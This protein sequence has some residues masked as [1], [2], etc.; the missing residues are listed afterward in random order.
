M[1][2]LKNLFIFLCLSLTISVK[3]Q[4]FDYLQSLRAYWNYRYHLVGDKVNRS[5]HMPFDIGQTPDAPDFLSPSGIGEP[6][7]M[8]VGADP[9]MSLPAVNIATYK[10]SYPNYFNPPY[11]N[12][13]STIGGS[14][15]SGGDWAI[16]CPT[17]SPAQYA[18]N[19]ASDGVCYNETHDPS[20]RCSECSVSDHLE[21]IM[22]GLSLTTQT[23]CRVGKMEC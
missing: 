3:G 22:K 23:M 18:Q 13:N 17:C 5:Q 7:I 15:N 21:F 11:P 6:G 16:I 12:N 1:N 19:W 20:T 4:G 14:W 9:G 8:V 10:V 2:K